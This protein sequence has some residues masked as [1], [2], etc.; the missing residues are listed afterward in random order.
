MTDRIHNW[1]HLVLGFSLLRVVFAFTDLISLLIISLFIFSI[2]T[3]FSLGKLHVSRNLSIPRFPIWWC[4][5]VHNRLSQSFVFLWCHCNVSYFVSDFTCLNS[6]SLVNLGTSL[7]V[8]FII[9]KSQLLLSLIFSVHSL[10]SISIFFLLWSLLI[11]SI[12]NF[13]LRVFFL[14]SL[15]PQDFLF[16]IVLVSLKNI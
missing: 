12:S 14:F 4:M 11:P 2:S 10:V 9:S 15:I 7:S 1:N 6:F 5:A 3:W 13:A 16:D 8:L